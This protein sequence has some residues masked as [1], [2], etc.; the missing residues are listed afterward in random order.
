MGLK[1]KKERLE[2]EISEKQS[3][4]EKVLKELGEKDSEKPKTRKTSE[5]KVVKQKQEKEKV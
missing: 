4:L 5:K 1:S 2:R 3:E